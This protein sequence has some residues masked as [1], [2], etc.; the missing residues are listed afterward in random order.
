MLADGRVVASIDSVFPVEQVDRAFD[1]LLERGKRGKVLVS[2]I[3]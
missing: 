2:F 1:R 3:A